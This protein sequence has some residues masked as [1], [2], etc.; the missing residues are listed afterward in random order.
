[1]KSLTSSKLT[2]KIHVHTSITHLLR[3]M[4][5]LFSKLTKALKF[6]IL[7]QKITLGR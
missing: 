2:F 1:M 4:R 7:R 5:E 3:Q 6:I